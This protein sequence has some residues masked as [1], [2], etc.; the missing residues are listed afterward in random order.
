M[1]NL[2]NPASQSA[3]EAGG[4]EKKHVRIAGNTDDVEPGRTSDNVVPAVDSC[5]DWTGV[6]KDS[7]R[8]WLVCAAA[9]SVQVF[10][11]GV[12]HIF[13]VFFVDLLEEFQ[14]SKGEAGWYS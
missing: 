9:F 5:V 2:P 13:G 14:C 8:A 12:L 7:G 6:K 11:V 4:P 3:I 1:D 10:I